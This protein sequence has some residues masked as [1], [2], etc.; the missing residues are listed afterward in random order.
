MKK[1][2]SNQCLLMVSL[3]TLVGC[4]SGGKG[5][6]SAAAVQVPGVA[7][8]TYHAQGTVNQGG[9]NNGQPQERCDVSVNSYIC[10]GMNGIQTGAIG[11]TSQPEFCNLL[12]DEQRNQGIAQATR[13]NIIQQSG[14][15]NQGGYNPNFPNGQVNPGFPPPNIPG[16]FP[17][18]LPNNP[19]LQIKNIN[20]RISVRKGNASG[21]HSMPVVAV[22][23]VANDLIAVVRSE[24]S[25]L[26]GWVNTNSEFYSNRFAKVKMTFIPGLGVDADMIKIS[27]DKVD[28][29]I[30]TSI[31]GYAG[32][33]VDLEILPDSQL[34][35]D[36][37][38]SV[39]CRSADASNPGPVSGNT[40]YS[41]S[42]TEKV[43]KD[44]EETV[45]GKIDYNED[46]MESTYG[47]AK[48]TNLVTEGTLSTG[49]GSVR[50]DTLSKGKLDSAI[51]GK[52]NV[53]TA[54]KYE[55]EKNGYA[56]KVSCR[57]KR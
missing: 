41:C 29:H 18:G 9:Y 50:F 6:G 37:Y 2:N 54:T 4:N 34:S 52:A 17:G 5:G 1:F 33:N 25:Y 45:F 8:G 39:T 10:V 15:L 30:K 31:T 51:S 28:G 14:C 56:L 55:V 26:N 38:V 46:L 23:G 49:L 48:K 19:S 42:G 3:L 20:C 44:K 11:F 43:G 24:N 40:K 7:V 36:T 12:R 35:D 21:D 22:A 57:P 47:I 27:A 53:T 16:Q 32:S 13:N